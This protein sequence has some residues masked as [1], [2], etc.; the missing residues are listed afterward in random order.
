MLSAFAATFFASVTFAQALT[1]KELDT[2]FDVFGKVIVFRDT[3]SFLVGLY[4]REEGGRKADFGWE[5]LDGPGVRFFKLADS[6]LSEV[7]EVIEV[8]VERG[9]YIVDRGWGCRE[10]RVAALFDALGNVVD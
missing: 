9:S 5:S 2:L 10:Y 3:L 7:A 4:L 1:N 8:V 6:E